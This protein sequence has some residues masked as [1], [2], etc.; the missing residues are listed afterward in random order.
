MHLALIY[1]NRIFYL[2]KL[3]TRVMTLTLPKISI[4]A[5]RITQIV[6]AFMAISLVRFIVGG[7]HPLRNFLTLVAIGIS[8][9]VWIW[10][11]QRNGEVDPPSNKRTY[12]L[13][14]IGA[15]FITAFFAFVRY[16][17]KSYTI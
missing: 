17:D 5:I 15:F 7:E 12:N 9:N 1:L 4:K 8:L 2:T 11:K 3:K 10:V 6:F 13:V 14:A 16:L